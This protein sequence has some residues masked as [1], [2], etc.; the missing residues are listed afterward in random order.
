MIDAKWVY[1]WKVDE[2]GWVVKAKSGLVACGF[3]QREGVDFREMFCVRLLSVIACECDL[4][5]CHLDVHQAFVQ[6]DLD[7]DV[8]QRLPKRYGDLSGKAVRLI[9][10]LYALKQASRKWHAYLTTCLKR[11]EFEQFIID[12]CVF[13]LVEDGRVAIT[14]FL[15]VDDI[16]AVG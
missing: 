14:A 2:H 13:R 9:K 11:L 7:E 1:R 8:F 16:F 15:H 10:R 12:A 5:L 6:S 4:D 3:K